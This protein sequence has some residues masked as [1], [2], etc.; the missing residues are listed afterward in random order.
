LKLIDS[1]LI[2]YSDKTA[3]EISEI[4][5]RD[6]PWKAAKEKE[7]INYEHVFYRSEE[8]SVGEYEEL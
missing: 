3:S 2:K 1:V 4:S 7:D 5:H 6:M 8:F